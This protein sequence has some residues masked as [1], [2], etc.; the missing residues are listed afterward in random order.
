MKHAA[1]KI[2]K[3]FS[4]YGRKLS[5]K[6]KTEEI[7]FE[8]FLQPLRYK[9]KMYLSAVHGELGFDTLTKF[10]LLCPG[11]IELESVDGINVKLCIGGSDFSVD[12]CEKFC[13]GEDVLYNWAIVHR[14]EGVPEGED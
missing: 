8:A 13:L 14:N 4:R 11:D 9:N 1:E 5:F 3:M 2:R 7:H 6:T 10:L 12:H